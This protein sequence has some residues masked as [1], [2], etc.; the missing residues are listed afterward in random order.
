MDFDRKISVGPFLALCRHVKEKL[1]E[2][3]TFSVKM[4]VK[5]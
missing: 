4:Y 5:G 2:R 3:V 1:C